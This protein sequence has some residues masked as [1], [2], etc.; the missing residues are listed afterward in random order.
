MNRTIQ[1]A[2]SILSADFADLKSVLEICE[3]GAAD[4]IHID[5]MDGH[6]V[7]NL[8]VGPVVVKWLRPH[9]K[10]FLDVHLMVS[11]PLEMIDPFVAAGADNLTFHIE[12]SDQP[13]TIIEKIRSS[14]IKVGLSL[15]PAT[16]VKALIDFLEYIDMVLVMTVEPGFGGQVFLPDSVRK[17]NELHEVL[18]AKNL[19]KRIAIEVDGGINTSTAS[20]VIAAGAD[21]LVAGSAIF[22][23]PDPIQ[24]IRDLRSV[25]TS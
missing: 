1:I 15:K 7:P 17:I 2:P 10:L 14:G 11:N 5:V 6:F 4:R 18:L 25:H 16:P 9:T 22:K 3:N 13:L 12:A 21:I 8:T 23:D 24:A 19:Q 20:E